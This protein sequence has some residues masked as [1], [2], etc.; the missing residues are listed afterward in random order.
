MAEDW[1]V[2]QSLSVSG[3]AK[4]NPP[5]S[6]CFSRLPPVKALVQA[7]VKPEQKSV[8]GGEHLSLQ[9]RLGFIVAASSKFG[10]HYTIAQSYIAW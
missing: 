6:T 2:W 1:R 8:L 5:I 9:S 7:L 10:R 4:P 3:H